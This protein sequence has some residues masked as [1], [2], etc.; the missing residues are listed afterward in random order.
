MA[1]INIKIKTL[2]WLRSHIICVSIDLTLEQD[3]LKKIDQILGQAQLVTQFTG[4][5][6]H[7]ILSSEF[8]LNPK[9][10][11]VDPDA[12]MRPVR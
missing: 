9:D 2:F 7:E 4:E 10:R 8:Q 1:P 3:Q 5:Y 6:N 11:K 12:E